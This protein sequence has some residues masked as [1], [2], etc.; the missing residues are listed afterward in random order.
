MDGGAA[1]NPG[2]MICDCKKFCP[3]FRI[4]ITKKTILRELDNWGCGCNV[5]KMMHCN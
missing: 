4:N 3:H 1:A 2:D 5:S